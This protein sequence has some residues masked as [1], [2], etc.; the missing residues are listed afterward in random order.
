MFV[1]RP[2]F[3]GGEPPTIVGATAFQDSVRDGKS[4]GHRAPEIQT[5]T[6]LIR[7]TT[8]S[9]L[10]SEENKVKEISIFHQLDQNI[11]ITNN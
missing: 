6:T 9:Y 5:L 3:A 7:A 2:I 8:S 1:P 10:K 11:L 4:W